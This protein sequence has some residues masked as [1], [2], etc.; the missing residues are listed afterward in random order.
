VINNRYPLNKRWKY[1]L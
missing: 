1:L